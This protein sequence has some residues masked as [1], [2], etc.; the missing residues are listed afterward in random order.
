[1]DIYRY[2]LQKSESE[3]ILDKRDACEKGWLAVVEAID[4]FLASKGR[5]LKKGDPL[6]HRK[7]FEILSEFAQCDTWWQSLLDK[8]LQ[9]QGALHGNCF[10]AGAQY[11]PVLD[12]YLKTTAREILEMTE[13]YEDVT[14]EE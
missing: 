11:S 12:K 8:Y 14:Q 10:Y 2:A 6:S 13:Q 3:V 7:R 5:I 4:N 9:V 1:M